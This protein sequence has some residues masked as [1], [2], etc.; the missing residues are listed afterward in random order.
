MLRNCFVNVRIA[1]DIRI[2]TITYRRVHTFFIL[3]FTGYSH[4]E[5]AGEVFWCRRRNLPFKRYFWYFLPLS[6]AIFN[7]IQLG[8]LC[9][10]LQEQCTCCGG[11]AF[12]LPRFFCLKQRQRRLFGGFF[13]LKN[14]PVLRAAFRRVFAAG[15]HCRSYDWKKTFSAASIFHFLIKNRRKLLQKWKG[16]LK[17]HPNNCYHREMFFGRRKALAVNFPH[18]GGKF[19]NLCGEGR[20]KRSACCRGD[21]FN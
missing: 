20:E 2:F 10:I 7:L 3:L 1:S 16:G 19:A 11:I 15:S 9:W 17:I 12:K 5:G 14:Q 4:C 8:K 21:F 13:A 6:A 18:W